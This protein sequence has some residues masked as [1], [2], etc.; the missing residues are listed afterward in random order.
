[1]ASQPGN[2]HGSTRVQTFDSDGV[3][4]AFIDE[5]AGEPVLLIHGFASSVRVQLGRPRLGEPPHR[6]TASA[7]SPSTTAA[8]ARA[9][10]STTAAL[11]GAPLMAE[12][13]RR[14]LDHLGIAARRRDGLL[15]GR[16]HHGVPGARASRARAQRHLRRARRQHGAADGRHRPDRRTRWRRPAIDEVKNP[17]ART[18][19]AFA[20][21]TG[22]DLKALAACI[23]GSREPI[24]REMVAT[25]GLPGAGGGRH[26]GRDRRLGRGAGRADPRRRGAADPAPRPHAAVGDRVYK[27]GVLAFPAAAAVTSARQRGNADGTSDSRPA[28]PT[29]PSAVRE[30]FARQGLMAHAGRRAS[31][32]SSR[33]CA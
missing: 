4:I 14:L 11:Y 15:D 19:R 30:S 17:T 26:R 31:S 2:R 10:S 8:T 23:R 5:G 20:E 12:D 28:I 7:S 9:R 16:A 32:R 22:S 3:R 6:A 1:M 29:T 13:A 25:L 27:E 24:T 33:G 21:K 18:F